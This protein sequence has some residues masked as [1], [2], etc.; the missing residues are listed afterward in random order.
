MCDKDQSIMR[1][2]FLAGAYIPPAILQPRL[3]F[4]VGLELIGEDQPENTIPSDK[5]RVFVR[6]NW[7][8]QTT[9]TVNDLRYSAEAS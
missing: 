7:T 2:I 5:I 4:N 8:I 1:V 9:V 3:F 6:F